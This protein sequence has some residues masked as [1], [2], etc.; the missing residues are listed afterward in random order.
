MGEIPT[1]RPGS[2]TPVLLESLWESAQGHLQ[3][4][5]AGLVQAHMQQDLALADA[6]SMTP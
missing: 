2:A 6:R 3:G 4:G 5:G 1:L